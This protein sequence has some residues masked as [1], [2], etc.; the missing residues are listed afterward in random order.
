VT[1][2]GPIDILVNNVGQRDRRGVDDLS[3]ADLRRLFDVHLASAYSMSQCV[4]TNMVELAS[5]FSARRGPY[6]LLYRIDDD[7]STVSILRVDHRAD[8]YRR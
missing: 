6:R 5:V 1:T 7:R 2:L 8:V 4:A 3:P